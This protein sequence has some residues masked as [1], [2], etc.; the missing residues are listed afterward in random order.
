MV[1]SGD[2]AIDLS[3]LEDNQAFEGPL[4]KGKQVFN[5]P[6]LNPFMELS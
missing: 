5:G 3:V 4:M 2:F 6:T 1:Y